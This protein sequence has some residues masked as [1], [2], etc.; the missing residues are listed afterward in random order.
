MS[1]RGLSSL[2]QTNH[3]RAEVVQE[4]TILAQNQHPE[5]HDQ[6]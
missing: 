2:S 1:F 3:S 4:S 5:A 6:I